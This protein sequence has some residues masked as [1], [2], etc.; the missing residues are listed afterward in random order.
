MNK[1]TKDILEWMLKNRVGTEFRFID[2]FPAGI[3][4]YLPSE[5]DDW[6]GRVTKGYT[7][8]ELFEI[9]KNSREK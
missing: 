1:E 8:E 5:N 4:F 2:G 7:S 6:D 3:I 9:F